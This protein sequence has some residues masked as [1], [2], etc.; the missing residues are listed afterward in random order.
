[1]L[2]AAAPFLAFAASQVQW[3]FK[4]IAAAGRLHVG[5]ARVVAR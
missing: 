3:E 1:M 2:L 4:L 5:R